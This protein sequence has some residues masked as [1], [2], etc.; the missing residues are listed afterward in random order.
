ME[1]LGIHHAEEIIEVSG[2]V[3]K[4]SA[5]DYEINPNMSFYVLNIPAENQFMALVDDGTKF[6]TIELKNQTELVK[7]LQEHLDAYSA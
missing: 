6:G 2:N 3:I 7:L 5:T 4:I 1:K